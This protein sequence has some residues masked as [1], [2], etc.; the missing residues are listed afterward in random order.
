M[1]V[2]SVQLGR[3]RRGDHATW[4]TRPMCKGGPPPQKLTEAPPEGAS[5]RA[6]CWRERSETATRGFFAVPQV[7]VRKHLRQ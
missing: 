7:A 6:P 1:S 5:K 3:S 2:K 4:Q